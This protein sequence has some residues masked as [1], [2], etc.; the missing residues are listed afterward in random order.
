MSLTVERGRQSTIHNYSRNGTE[1]T[2]PRPRNSDS[3]KKTGGSRPLEPLFQRRNLQVSPFPFF[4][5]MSSPKSYGILSP[6]SSPDSR[7]PIPSEGRLPHT[8]SKRNF[9]SKP[10][11]HSP[12]QTVPA[13]TPPL[14]GLHTGLV[15]TDIVD[16]HPSNRWF[17]GPEWGLDVTKRFYRRCLGE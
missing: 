7:L 13:M 11:P 17:S 5:L 4:S 10:I 16:P 6:T 15:R 14:L 8:D 2:V 9:P 12:R 3:T 1:V